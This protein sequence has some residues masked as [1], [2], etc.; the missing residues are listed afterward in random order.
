MTPQS[1]A[2]EGNDLP[3]T[4]DPG[5]LVKEVKEF[6]FPLETSTPTQLEPFASLASF[7]V[8]K[9]DHHASKDLP[10]SLKY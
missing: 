3:I 9:C 1:A 10:L 2:L 7:R 8:S 6:M 4:G 5:A